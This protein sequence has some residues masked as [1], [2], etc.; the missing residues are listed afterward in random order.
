M[1][2]IFSLIVLSLCFQGLV[3]QNLN[4]DACDT[5]QTQKEI[6]ACI[7][8]MYNVS[9]KKL[10]KAYGLFLKKL[11]NNIKSS[12]ASEVKR[13][14]ELKQFYKEGQMQWTLTRNLN[15]DTQGS[16]QLTKLL[17]EY[18]FYVSK[19][20]ESLDRI[21]YLEKLSDTLNLK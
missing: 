14:Q 5:L 18:A 20:K 16:F 10:D 17:S 13:A 2:S 9:Q 1:K 8:K 21:V 19:T 15:A 3:A 6:N 7:F 11:D 12:K 4:L